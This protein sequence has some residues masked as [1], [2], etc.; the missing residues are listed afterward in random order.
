MNVGPVR[1]HIVGGP[2]AGKSTLAHRLSQALAVPAYEL[3]DLR[4]A[5]A[6]ARDGKG[7]FLAAQRPI[8][9]RRADARSIAMK[10]EWITEGVFISWTEDLLRHADLVIWLDVPWRVAVAKIATRHVRELLASVSSAGGV[11]R[12]LGRLRHPNVRWLRD[13][14]VVTTAYYLGVE[15][16]AALDPGVP[17]G[18]TRRATAIFLEPYAEK[19][20]RFTH[21]RE[22]LAQLLRHPLDLRQPRDASGVAT[23]ST[24]TAR[25]RST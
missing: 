10:S 15:S 25:I 20:L 19:I 14:V 17:G 6:G 4:G 1:I 12:A 23:E 3:D 22:A 18:L 24:Q 8:A 13:L 16:Q 21:P 11:R 2:G 5:G 7:R 9:L